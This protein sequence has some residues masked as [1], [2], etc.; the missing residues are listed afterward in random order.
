[1]D[2]ATLLSPLLVISADDLRVGLSLF[3]ASDRLGAFERSWQRPPWALTRRPLS[4]R[5]ALSS[6]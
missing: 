4:Q 1:M 6:A 2:Y 3:E 5:T